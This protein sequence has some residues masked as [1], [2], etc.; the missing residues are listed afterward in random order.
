MMK[1][2]AIDAAL[3]YID[4]ALRLI[5]DDPT[6]IGVSSRKRRTINK[7]QRALVSALNELTAAKGI[8]E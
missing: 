3:S 7:A 8:E 1:P 4:S 6:P 5:P 2:W